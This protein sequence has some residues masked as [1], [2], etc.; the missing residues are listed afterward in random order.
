M[1]Q[2]YVEGS[3][4]AEGAREDAGGGGGGRIVL[5]LSLLPGSICQVN[6][7]AR[8]AVHHTRSGQS[9]QYLSSSKRRNLLPPPTTR[10]RMQ[11]T[12]Q[13]VNFNDAQRSAMN[14]PNPS[15]NTP[16]PIPESFHLIIS[17]K[18]T[19]PNPIQEIANEEILSTWHS[20]Q[21]DSNSSVRE[22]EHPREEEWRRHPPPR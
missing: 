12:N 2:S 19:E 4:P 8:V 3:V 5:L 18:Q 11:L 21:P 15:P 22:R 17:P 7:D 9:S 16:Q 10:C 1:L 14:F 20:K 6:D 13:P